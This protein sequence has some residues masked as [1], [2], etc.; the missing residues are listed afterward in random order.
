M[1]QR[2]GLERLTGRFVRHFVRGQ[3]PQFLI[4]QWQQFVPGLGVALFHRSEDLSDVAHW[5]VVLLAR[6]G[7]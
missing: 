6:C 3:P 7:G 1:H 5:V 4:D 2:G